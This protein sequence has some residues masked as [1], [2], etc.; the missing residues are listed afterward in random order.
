VLDLLLSA[1]CLFG[2]PAP[3]SSAD[4]LDV[5]RLPVAPVVDGRVDEREYGAPTLRIATAAGDVR[6][7]VVRNED[8]IYLAAD[9]PDSTFYWGD[10][11]VV[12]LDPD[13]RGGA[14]PGAGDRQWYLRRVLDS[15]V[16]ALAENGRWHA[17]GHSPPMLGPRRHD[18]AWD[19]ASTTSTVGW[20]VELRVRTTVVK[21]GVAAPRIAFRTYNDHPSGWWSWPA[22]PSGVSAQEVEKNPGRWVPLRFVR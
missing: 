16:V 2:L 5:V 13:G 17:P 9:A 4:T 8:F 11:F 7:W 14:S 19:V 22:P 10:D 15:S 1:A 18:D 3:T 20:S 12:S 21:P 6:V